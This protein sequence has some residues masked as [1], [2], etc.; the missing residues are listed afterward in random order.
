MNEI[1]IEFPG[2]RALNQV[3]FKAS[4]GMVHALIG[5]NGAGKSTL[6][7]VLSGAYTHYTGDILMNA[8]P[9]TIRSPKHAQS[10]G[11]QIVYQEVDTALITSLTVGENIMLNDT[12]NQMKNKHLIHWRELH[13][14]ATGILNSMNIKVSSKALVSELTLAEKQMVL[15]ARS[16]STECRFLIL[17]EPTAPLSHSEALEL[18][19][20]IK[21]LKKKNVGI[22]FISHRLPELFTICDEITVMRNGE[23]VAREAISDTTQTRVVELMLGKKLEEQFPNKHTNIEKPVLEVQGL[24]DKTKLKDINF[25]VQAGEIVGIAGL[26]GAGKTELCKVLFGYTAKSKG[27]IRLKGKRLKLKTPYDAVK[28]HIA[29]VPEERRKEGVLVEE[30]VMTNLTASSLNRFTSPFGF[31]NVRSEKE[32]AVEMINRLNIKTPSP[33]TIVQHLSGGNQQKIAIGKW[34]IADAEVYIFDEPTKGVDVGAKKDIF[35]LI[36]E[37]ARRGKAVLYASSELAEIIG[38]THRVYIMYDG[39]FVKELE[40][41]QSN[42]EQL[43]YYSTGGEE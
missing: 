18:F 13:Q 26:V 8:E 32:K 42:E 28:S 25:T 21:E 31:L 33:E 36:I 12:V 29:L 2:V 35:D 6:M 5:A 9:V 24:F 19:R 34:L 16:I 22:I 10:L 15:I 40:T 1:S 3:N 17:D 43:L 14:R 23:F 38:I 20:I 11:I 30:S 37:L 39:Q 7:K 27:T 41:D 4:T